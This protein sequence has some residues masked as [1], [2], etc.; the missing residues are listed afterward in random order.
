MRRYA[1]PALLLGTVVLL[2]ACGR[3]S[4]LI[5]T[6]QYWQASQLDSP[7]VEA[8]LARAAREQHVRISTVVV[9]YGQ[10]GPASLIEALK[11]HNEPTVLLS[12][13]YSSEA[14]T[15][16]ANFTHRRFIYFSSPGHT[17]PHPANLVGAVSDPGPAFR[18]AGERVGHYLEAK[19]R[20]SLEGTLRVAAVFSDGSDG[21]RE[22]AEF[23]SG[24][25]SGKVRPA[26]SV[27]QVNG[28]EDRSRVLHFLREEQ[29]DNAAV[30]VLAAPSL[31]A[32]A[33]EVLNESTTPI[34]TENWNYGATFS[35]KILFSIDKDIG[36]LLMK[37]VET[38]GRPADKE[39]RVP[40]DIV[41]A[42]GQS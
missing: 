38:M 13:L 27:I 22:L 34:V 32:Y 14:S 4:V 5:L 29:A 23:H 25:E 10:A 33:I 6:D 8:A 12:P 15:V 36:S 7:P 3:A 16:A 40:W 26:L 20:G 18:R 21:Q 19:N 41:S 37:I 9:P 28:T 42:A 31:N 11:H 30:F 1:L 2:S 24:L 35:N 39:I 17:T